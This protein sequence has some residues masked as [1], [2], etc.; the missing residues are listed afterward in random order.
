[1]QLILNLFS[2]AH[3]LRQSQGFRWRYFCPKRTHFGWDKGITT[4]DLVPSHSPLLPESQACSACLPNLAE[5]N[6]TEKRSWE[7]DG[8]VGAV[9]CFI[10]Q[11]SPR[12]FSGYIRFSKT[13]MD[14]VLRW[15]CILAKAWWVNYCFPK[16][17]TLSRGAW[18]NGGRKSYM[19][20]ETFF[21]CDEV[22]T[23]WLQT[24]FFS[25]N[26]PQRSQYSVE[27]LNSFNVDLKK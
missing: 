15:L 3:N 18:K 5:C 23:G 19:Y 1:M 2:S 14:L 4:W 20:G 17:V 9:G 26:V 27:S 16:K 12:V 6:F 8:E 25:R 21:I 7:H 11:I 13:L 24:T 22:L 10:N